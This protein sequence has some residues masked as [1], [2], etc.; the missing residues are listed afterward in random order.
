MQIAASGVAL[1]MACVLL[2][3]GLE[4]A[5]N[6]SSAASALAQLGVPATSV[7]AAAA[8]LAAL[9]AA[10]ALGLIFRPG[11]VATLAGVLGLAGAFAIAGVIA[12]R[13]NAL[14][15]CGCF[16]PYGDASLGM[17][18]VA[19]LPLWL[20]GVALLW[21]QPPGESPEA[22]SASLLAVAGL[23]MAALR[24]ANALKAARHARDDRRSAEEMF[25]W[26]PR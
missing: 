11:A 10:V 6:L 19:A 15:R 24:A 7:R 8:L 17:N 1:A 16:G 22:G 25:L 2:W 9:E 3:A 23:A 18:Q 12:L 4:K 13:R 20:G 5:R 14:I 26:L 21:L